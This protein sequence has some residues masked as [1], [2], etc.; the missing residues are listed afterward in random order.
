MNSEEIWVMLTESYL[1]LPGI[2]QIWMGLTTLNEKYVGLN[3]IK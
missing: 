1:L 3:D 2:Y